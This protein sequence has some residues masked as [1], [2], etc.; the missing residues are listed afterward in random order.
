MD[1]GLLTNAAL[2]EAKSGQRRLDAR[3]VL[4]ERSSGVFR[5]RNGVKPRIARNAACG[6][7]CAQEGAGLTLTCAQISGALE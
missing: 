7:G 3:T 1:F 4:R 2:R 5:R 6:A